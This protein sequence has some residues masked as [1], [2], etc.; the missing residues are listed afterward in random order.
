MQKTIGS[1]MLGTVLIGAS[2]CSN[3]S[4]AQAQKQVQEKVQKQAQKTEVVA[5]KVEITNKALGI[6]S[7]TYV[8]DKTHGSVTF[9][10]L[11]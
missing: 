7:G 11:H 3:N 6:P 9:S 4:D 1:L 8:M 5:Q 10:Y 2:A